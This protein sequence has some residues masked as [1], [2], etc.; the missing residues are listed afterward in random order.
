MCNQDRAPR[1]PTLF[2]PGAVNPTGGPN[3]PD[4]GDHRGLFLGAIPL[5]VAVAPVCGGGKP[6]PRDANGRPEDPAIVSGR[7]RGLIEFARA[8]LARLVPHTPRSV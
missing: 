4:P 7:R 2:G 1:R 3:D 8:V 5:L 6:W